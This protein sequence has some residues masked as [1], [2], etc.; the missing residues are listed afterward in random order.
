MFGAINLVIDN[1]CFPSSVCGRLFHKCD[2]DLK[3]CQC[4][5]SHKYDRAFPMLAFKAKKF[6]EVFSVI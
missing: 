4:W 3:Y 2:R 1:L 5:M 6:I